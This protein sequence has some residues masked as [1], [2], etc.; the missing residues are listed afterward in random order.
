MKALQR[1]AFSGPALVRLLA[2]LTDAAVPESGQ[3][4]S[5]RL[6][7]WLGWTDAIALS[8]ALNGGLPAASIAPASEAA[9]QTECARVRQALSDAI[10]RDSAFAGAKRRARASADAAGAQQEEA[11]EYAFFRQ[12]YLSMQQAMETDIGA[13]RVRLRAML[14]A[15]RPAI[16]RL[17]LVDAVMERA[18]GVREKNALA[19][20]PVLLGAHFERLGNARRDAQADASA[21]PEGAAAQPG[22]WLDV[23]RQDMQSVL[24][25]ELNIRF[26][27]VEGLLAALRT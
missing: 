10:A 25:A 19:A 17:A 2:R 24:F 9:A 8:T 22:P 3:P 12:R 21:R 13:L 14:S 23:F 20:V 15:A 16:A 6:S 27:P 7:Q 1:T 18:L 4:L 5:E 26:Q 11:P